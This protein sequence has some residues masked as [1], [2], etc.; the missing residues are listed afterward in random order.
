MYQLAH[1]THL[2]R[3]RLAQLREQAR[4]DDGYTTETIVI[5]ALLAVLA[6]AVV[7]VIV[8]KVTAKANGISLD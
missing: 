5:T 6:I 1:M 8:T 2:V 3:E 7:G 4:R